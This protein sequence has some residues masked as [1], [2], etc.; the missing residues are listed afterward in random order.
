M[1]VKIRCSICGKFIKYSDIGTDKIG[2]D[3]TPDSEFTIESHEYY[4]KK[5]ERA[6]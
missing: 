4:H 2:Y 3:F 6:G 1:K 5:C